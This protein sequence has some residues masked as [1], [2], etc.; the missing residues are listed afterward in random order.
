MRIML[1]FFRLV[2]DNAKQSS[3]LVIT[4]LAITTGTIIVFL[5]LYFSPFCEA[6]IQAMNMLAQMSLVLLPLSACMWAF[7]ITAGVF[8]KARDVLLIKNKHFLSKTLLT[9]FLINAALITLMTVLSC[10][11]AKDM[12]N[13]IILLMLRAIC[14]SG[15]YMDF[16]ALSSYFIRIPFIGLTVS[17]YC[18]LLAY[19]NYLGWIRLLP[20]LVTN[21]FDLLGSFWCSLLVMP[22]LVLFWVSLYHCE[23]TVK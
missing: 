19:A 6:R 22:F 5:L 17:L 7:A 3:W 11:L 18:I 12:A 20:P 13:E 16:V 2:V 8:E 15:L 4:S 10:L 1:R 21:F 9:A 23:T 14:I